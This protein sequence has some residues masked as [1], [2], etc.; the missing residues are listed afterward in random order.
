MKTLGVF[1]LGVCFVFLFSS[2]GYEKWLDTQTIMTFRDV[3]DRGQQTTI[4][5]S[6]Q[7]QEG[8]RLVPK[9][10][11]QSINDID[12]LTYHYDITMDEGDT[13]NVSALAS[14]LKNNQSMID[15]LGMIEFDIVVEMLSTT[16]AHVTVNVS[17]RMP[18]T[19]A[20]YLFIQGSQ[21]SFNLSFNHTSAT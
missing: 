13:L 15:T 2:I 5:Q 12:T 11:F 14:I 10:S 16:L 19:E 4:T 17:L 6:L 21:I 7:A 9:G 18:Q 1:F 8:Q 20:E 3:A